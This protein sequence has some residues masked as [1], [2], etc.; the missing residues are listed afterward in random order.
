VK[1][2]SHIYLAS[3]AL[4]LMWESVENY[5]LLSGKVIKGKKKAKLHNSVKKLQELMRI[6]KDDILEATWAPDALLKDMVPYHT[7]KLFC[8]DEFPNQDFSAYDNYNHNGM[9]YYR[10]SGSG[11]PYKIDH[12]AIVIKNL[13][14]LRTFNDAFSMKQI[15]Y[16][17]FMLTHYIS[18]LNV[19]M[20][21]DLR[22]DPPSSTD[23]KKPKGKYMKD[24][25][26]AKVEKLWDI[27]VTP[28]ALELGYINPDRDE[29]DKEKNPA[30]TKLITF[31]HTDAKTGQLIAPKEIKK[32]KLLDFLIET[33]IRSKD[34]SRKL[35]PLNNPQLYKKNIIENN[36]RQIFAHAI[37]DIISVWI[38]IWSD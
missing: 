7:F 12:L 3:S 11:A 6:H 16:L 15:M 18:D 22:D 34:M 21:C 5:T 29:Y 37:S 19:P 1:Q 23:T 35:F 27:A 36:T 14:K 2:N 20:H 31:E 4:N 28:K 26:H 10:Y 9:I 24:S 33:A 8:D 30:L 17:L 13:I 38:Y 32:G 25:T